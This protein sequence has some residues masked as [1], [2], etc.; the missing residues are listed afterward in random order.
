MMRGS[1]TIRSKLSM[2]LRWL[3]PE[4][5]PVSS[6]PDRSALRHQLPVVSRLSLHMSNEPAEFRKLQSV[7]LRART[8]LLAQVLET[9]A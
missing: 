8:A 1:V 3:E 4:G 7:E 6:A 5:P 9:L 2:K